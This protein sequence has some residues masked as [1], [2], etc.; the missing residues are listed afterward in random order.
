MGTTGFPHLPSGP[1]FLPGPP[2]NGL[3]T[4]WE[5]LFGNGWPVG[6]CGQ[7]QAEG[8]SLEPPPRQL[9]KTCT[10]ARGAGLTED[11]LWSEQAQQASSYRN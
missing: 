11:Q 3:G 1:P 4:V 8:R 6:S 7:T 5:R 10:Q 9:A 2:R